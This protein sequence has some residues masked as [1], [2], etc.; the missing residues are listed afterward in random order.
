[1]HCTCFT[2][3]IETSILENFITA[4]VEEYKNRQVA[5]AINELAQLMALGVTLSTLGLDNNEI[6]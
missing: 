6:S 3:I 4:C 2:L 1:M 5:S